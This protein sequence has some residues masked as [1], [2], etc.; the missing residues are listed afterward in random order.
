MEV[1][2]K[3]EV[4]L[5][6]AVDNSVKNK[7]CV[8][9]LETKVELKSKSLGSVSAKLDDCIAGKALRSCCKD[10]IIYLSFYKAV[11]NNQQMKSPKGHP[12]IA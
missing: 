10:V 7:F 2:G 4:S 9:W 12:S 11:M 5:A 3:D 8:E 6:R 1:L